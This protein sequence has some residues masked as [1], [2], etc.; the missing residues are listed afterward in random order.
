MHGEFTTSQ[1]IERNIGTIIYL[2]F[3]NHGRLKHSLPLMQI[4]HLCETFLGRQLRT[5]SR[6]QIV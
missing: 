3:S 5:K 6:C 2:H 4:L 1:F